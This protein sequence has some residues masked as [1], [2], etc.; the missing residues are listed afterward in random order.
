MRNITKRRIIIGILL[1]IGLSFFVKRCIKATLSN[2]NKF[3]SI[4][5]YKGKFD[6]EDSLLF[7]IKELKNIRIISVM[8]SNYR[9]DIKNFS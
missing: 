9:N 3:D 7:K 2:H 5:F 4:Y 6:K 8:E 1:V